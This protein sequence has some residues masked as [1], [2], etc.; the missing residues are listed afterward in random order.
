MVFT[1]TK[2]K[3]GKKY[4]YR[5]KSVR[6]GNKITRERKYLG[7]N[8]TEKELKEQENKADQELEVLSHLLTK[9]E[10][11]F[12]ETAKKSRLKQ[13]QEN[14]ENRYEAFVSKF[15]YDSNAIEGNTLTLQETSQLLFDKVVPVSKSLREVNEAL[16]HKEAFDY[17][18]HYKGD[19]TKKF[20]LGLH[21]KVVK[22]TLKP[23]LV[24]QIGKYRT[25]RVYIRGVEWTPI[26]PSE[27][28]NE[29][30]SLLAWY[31]RAKKKL[32]PLVVA[33]Y[34]HVGFET[35]HPFVDGNGR[36]GRL[37]MNYILHKNKYPMIN[38]PNAIKARYY[39]ALHSAQV[40][41]DMRPF[42]ELLIDILKDN[43]VIL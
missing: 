33:A 32:H 22:E 18:L 10:L 2:Q 5:V 35:V 28:P 42:V 16:N 41:G 6:K 4:Y 40:K 21:K 14:W 19:I 12:L 13:P 30:K 25:V 11:D 1:E 7:V 17:M 36:V 24:S 23:E 38:I 39:S 9:E 26:K 34:F 37:L 3:G 43:K 31:S 15:T 29:M 27:V 8:L 20:I